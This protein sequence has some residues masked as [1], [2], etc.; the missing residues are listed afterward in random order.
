LEPL[1]CY[2]R[3]VEIAAAFF[4]GLWPHIGSTAP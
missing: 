4:D 3:S 1:D 2:R